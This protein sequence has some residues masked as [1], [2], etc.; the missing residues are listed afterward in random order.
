VLRNLINRHDAVRFGRK[1]RRG[2]AR[3][4]MAKLRAGEPDRVLARWSPAGH[5]PEPVQWDEIPA[6]RRRWHSFGNGAAQ[7]S[8]AEQVA[9]TWLA[10]R[11]GLRALS[12]GCG[13]G[14]W[15]MDLARLGLF[16]HITGIDISPQQI[17]RA[18]QRAKEAGLDGALSFYVAD[19]RQALREEEQ[20]DIVLAQQSL[21][22]FDHLAETVG[23][24]AQALRPGGLL[25]FDEY[26]G[27]SRFQ[28]TKAQMRAA[29]ALLAA[30]PAERR[31]QSDGRIKQRVIRPSLLSMR[32]DDPSEA[33]EASAL[34]PSL[35]RSFVV[36]E[37]HPYGGMLHLALHGIA[38]HFLGQ[39]AATAELIQ[40]CLAAED[41]ALDRLGHD[42]VYAVCT[43]R[44]QPTD[45][46]SAQVTVTLADPAAASCGRSRGAGA[47]G[48]PEPAGG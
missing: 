40:Q 48:L 21:H 3:R 22:H 36:L 32:L 47:D 18:T 2:N 17:G 16:E 43:P 46:A 28:W 9:R 38:H 35:R 34:L 10:G 37:E 20:Y 23:L 30:L 24:M 42:F 31:T 19:V 25:I 1:L 13:T 45:T 4:I 44:D 5:A 6:V 33:V 39:D 8:F 15:E 7:I 41:E 11:S 29:N 26:V 12:I 14:G 27:P